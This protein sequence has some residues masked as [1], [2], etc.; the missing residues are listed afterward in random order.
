[1]LTIK[2]VV[3]M[4]VSLISVIILR[5][6]KGNIQVVPVYVFPSLLF[7]IMLNV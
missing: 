5:A 2:C 7:E 1:M 4:N 3:N 6:E